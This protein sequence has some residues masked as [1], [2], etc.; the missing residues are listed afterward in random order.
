ML[1]RSI[2]IV[3]IGVGITA[4]MCW[5]V[6]IYAAQVVVGVWLGDRLLGASVGIGPAL[7]RL[8]LGLLILRAVGLVPY[9]GPWVNSLVIC[10]G[11]GAMVL[12]IYRYM[13]PN[14]QAAAVV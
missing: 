8:A 12:A 4:L 7:G 6:A 10:L 11:M 3:G 9:L 5:A 14:L 13:R 2:T 1:F